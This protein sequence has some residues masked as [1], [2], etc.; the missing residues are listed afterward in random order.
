MKGFIK[1]TK[2]TWK[3]YLVVFAVVLFLTLCDSIFTCVENNTA[4]GGKI[5]NYD[6]GKDSV[7]EFKEK[8]GGR[9]YGGQ[10]ISDIFTDKIHNYAILGFGF[11]IILILLILLIKQFV[12]IDERTKEF[13]TVL[14]VKQVTRVFHDYLFILGILVFGQMLQVGIF[15]AYQTRYNTELMETAKKFSVT[16][17]VDNHTISGLN[18]RLLIY[19]GFY[20]LFLVAA[21]TWIYLWTLVTKNPIVGSLSSIVL[22]GAVPF[23]FDIFLDNC[24]LPFGCGDYYWNDQTYEF[25][26][27]VE[28]MLSPSDFF[29]INGLD[30]DKHNYLAQTAGAMVG[31]VLLMLV[32]ILLVGCKRELSK[33]KLFYFPVLD[34]PFSF[35]TGILAVE[36]VFELS[37]F[38]MSGMVYVLIWMMATVS[39][40][41][42]IHPF[43]LRKSNSWE[44]K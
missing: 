25:I 32:L 24:I 36:L 9:L 34:Y 42:L 2:E 39:I 31:F 22:W 41:I 28:S 6:M 1:M 40:F 14:P 13:Q 23:L 17:F 20:L 38:A 7:E 26:T 18:E 8:N 5:F 19:A 16:C 3:F 44:V 21:Y 33:G 29:G 10:D 27:W 30:L 37:M 15:L 12:F 35:L 4:Y 43:S 11:Q